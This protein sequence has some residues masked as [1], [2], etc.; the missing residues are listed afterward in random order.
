MGCCPITKKVMQSAVMAL[1]GHTYE[2]QAIESWFSNH[3]TTSPITGRQLDSRLLVPNH[4]IRNIV[5][6]FA[7]SSAGF[8]FASS[9]AT[10][11]PRDVLDF[12]FGAIDG[13]SLAR[14]A[15][16]CN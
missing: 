15:Q 10:D 3:G 1:D 5:R 4:A 12:V 2:R 7:L 9:G 6:V 13:C 11:V 16:V 14:C 8:S